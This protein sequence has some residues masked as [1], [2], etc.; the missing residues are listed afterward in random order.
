MFVKLEVT[1]YS[2]AVIMAP[3][4][5]LDADKLWD[6]QLAL[7]M[8]SNTN[9]TDAD[10]AHEHVIGRSRAEAEVAV[11][12]VPKYSTTFGLDARTSAS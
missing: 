5:K 1:W 3:C 7:A 12:A 4:N 6:A 2:F 11:D 10:L 8:V 9:E